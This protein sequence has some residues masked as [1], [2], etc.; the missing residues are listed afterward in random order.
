V[1]TV[2]LIAPDARISLSK[3]GLPFKPHTV[4]QQLQF[5]EPVQ[6][7]DKWLTFA[8]GRW[9]I[10]VDRENVTRSQNDGTQG[11]FEWGV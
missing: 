2:Y 1:N 9:L 5:A 6:T 7:T 3:D 4:K 11:Q 10:K 8:K